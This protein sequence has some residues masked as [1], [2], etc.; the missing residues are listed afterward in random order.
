MLTAALAV[1]HLTTRES[2]PEGA[3]RLSFQGKTVYLTADEI[4]KSH[5]SGTLVNG[6]GE[7][8][9][10]DAMGIALMDALDAQSVPVSEITRIKI[11]AQDA[12]SAEVSG[13]ELRENGKIYLTARD[14]SVTLVVFGDSNSK[15]NVRDVAVIDVFF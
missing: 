9:S 3:V 6:K 15:R 14:N 7:T 8:V 5:I 10:V 13:A 4:E 11:T 2:V 1:L 12:F